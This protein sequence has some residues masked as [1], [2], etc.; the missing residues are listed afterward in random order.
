MPATIATSTPPPGWAQA[1]GQL[2][3]P[4]F[5]LEPLTEQQKADQ[6]TAVA[7]LTNAVGLDMSKYDLQLGVQKHK[8]Y[9]P[10]LPKPRVEETVLCKLS[11]PE[12]TLNAMLFFRGN[13]VVWCMLDTLKGSPVFSGAKL[14]EL[15]TAKNILE[16]GQNF[17]EKTDLSSFRNTLN[18]ISTIENSTLTLGDKKLRITIEQSSTTFEWSPSIGDINNNQQGLVITLNDGHFY[19]YVNNYDL[20]KTG[21]TE[22]KVSKDQA[23]EIAKEHAHTYVWTAGNTTVSNVTFADVPAQATLSMQDR[24]NYTLY[25]LWQLLLPLD[26][27][28]PG[29]VSSIQVE[30]W[31]DN[32]EVGYM[33]ASG[34]GGPPQ[35]PKVSVESSSETSSTDYLIAAI[36]VVLLAVIAISSYLFY[37]RKR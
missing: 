5:N 13:S 33:T 37:K 21:N 18:S 26:K 4:P 9:D 22:V 27:V 25:P 7:F 29:L 10:K 32:G 12:T 15:S 34:A 3:P 20:Y 1:S 2:T 6:N 36:L 28:Y 35:T 31:A 16:K 19:F 14:D 8:P 11:N 23:I 17:S 30:V 24:G